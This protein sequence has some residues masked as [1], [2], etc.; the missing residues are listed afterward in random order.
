METWRSIS[1]CA[2]RR[3][4][5]P[6]ISIVLAPRK[7]N[8]SGFAIRPRFVKE[9]APLVAAIVVPLDLIEGRPTAPSRFALGEAR[10]LAT[11]FG[12]TVLGLVM[13]DALSPTEQDALGQSAGT[14]GADKVLL[15]LSAQFSG[16]PLDPTHG[17]FLVQ[18][19]DRLRP[20]LILFPAGGTGWQLGP[21]LAIRSQAAFFPHAALG[22]SDTDP[23]RLLLGRWRGRE[24]GSRQLDFSEIERPVVAILPTGK[25][26]GVRGNPVDLQEVDVPPAEITAPPTVIDSRPDPGAAASFARTLVIVSDGL[27]C[28]AAQWEGAPDDLAVLASGQ[29]HP[30]LLGSACPAHVFLLDPALPSWARKAL[31][32]PLGGTVV[33]LSGTDQWALDAIL[34]TDADEALRQV[35]LLAATAGLDSE[36]PS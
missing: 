30:A 11:A 3:N 20:L 34:Q 27:A 35:T 18:M 28:E 12:A 4:G 32:P 26:P 10:R 9:C 6:R 8:A 15:A 19:A 13:T 31:R 33:G 21:S 14:A 24:Q 2:I 36:D 25:A 5:E 16:P 22:I 1:D 29:L 17:P 7:K 23:P